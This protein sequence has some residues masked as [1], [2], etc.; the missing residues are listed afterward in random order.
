MQRPADPNYRWEDVYDYKD[1]S[2]HAPG[3]PVTV[4]NTVTIPKGLDDIQLK[5]MNIPNY[6]S[7]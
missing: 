1:E 2:Y 4:S 6:T 7:K 3:E 5:N